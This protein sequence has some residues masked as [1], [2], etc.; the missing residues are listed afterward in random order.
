[1]IH[2]APR[3]QPTDSLQFH[4]YFPPSSACV[5][6]KVEERGRG[7]GP[8]SSTYKHRRMNKK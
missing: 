7:E 8:T 5:G 3:I 1:M 2:W 4:Y 6:L